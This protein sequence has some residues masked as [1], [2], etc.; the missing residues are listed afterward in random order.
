MQ[1]EANLFKVYVQCDHKQKVAILK[2]K[3]EAML[4]YLLGKNRLAM[5]RFLRAVLLDASRRT[6]HIL[7]SNIEMIESVEDMCRIA[8]VSKKTLYKEV[9][10]SYG[11][12]P[13]MWIDQN[14]LQRAAFLLQ[15]S[16]KS[17]AEIAS[18]C[19]FS[20][21][22]WFGVRF[23]QRYRLTPK[24]YQKKFTVNDLI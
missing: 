3:T 10:K 20:T 18:E 12:T 4:L 21:L 8:K 11:L 2:L 16:E 5:H 9:K 17:I 6:I 19:G 7:E 1:K 14:R 15:H 22:S 24:A 13:K 23:K